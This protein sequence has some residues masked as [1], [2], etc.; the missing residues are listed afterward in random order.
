MDKNHFKKPYLIIIIFLIVIIGCYNT[1]CKKK[2][3]TVTLHPN[4]ESLSSEILLQVEKD[5]TPNFPNLI[6]DGYYFDG[7]FFED[8]K[9]FTSSMVITSKVDLYA[10]WTRI[11]YQITFDSNGGTV[12]QEKVLIPSGE[13]I[14]LPIPTKEGYIFYGWFTL[15]NN[16]YTSSTPIN[17]NV[18][19]IAKWEIP[20]YNITY[21]NAIIDTP[22]YVN[23]NE[24][25]IDF[26]N[27][28]TSFIR[29]EVTLNT[30]INYSSK[31][32]GE[33]GFFSN[34]VLINKWSWLLHYLEETNNCSDITKFFN[35]ESF[36]KDEISKLIIAFINSNINIDTYV[37]IIG[38]GTSNPLTYQKGDYYLL[39][40]PKSISKQ[41]FLGWFNDGERVDEIN[42]M[43][44]INLTLEAKWTST[45]NKI[46]F[47]L[48]GGAFG[49]D[50][51]DLY[52]DNEEVILPIPTYPGYR[53]D[54]WYS[55][56]VCYTTTKDLTGSVS[57]KAKWIEA[58][59]IVTYKNAEITSNVVYQTRSDM[60]ND[61]IND[62]MSYTHKKITINTFYSLTKEL[63]FTN[64]G[65]F[66]DKVMNNKWNWM[67][68]YLRKTALTNAR[69]EIELFLAGSK[70]NNEKYI[71]QEIQGFITETKCTAYSSIN[72]SADYTNS[73]KANGYQEDLEYFSGDNP[74]SYKYGENYKLRSPMPKEKQLFLGWSV[75]NQLVLEITSDMSCDLELV[76]IWTNKLCEINYNLNNGIFTN[77]YYDLY[78]PGNIIIDLPIPEK[79]NLVFM[80]WYENGIRRN[81]ITA[82]CISDITLDAKWGYG[83]CQVNYYNYNNQLLYTDEIEKYEL[84]I[85]RELASYNNL[86]LNWYNGRNIYDFTK[87]VESNLDLYARWGVIED[88]IDSI[89][90]SEISENL[91]MI[92]EYETPI[93]KMKIDWV[94]SNSNLVNVYN[95]K[96]NLSLAKKNVLIYG[97]FSVGGIE[98]THSFEVELKAKV[99]KSLKDIKPVFAYMANYMSYFELNDAVINTIDVI[100]YGFARVNKDFTINM[101]ELGYVN[102]VLT[103]RD[104]GIRVLLCIGAY[105]A[106]CVPFSD[107][108]ATE[109][110][111]QLLAKN[112]V[113]MVVKYGF[114]G[115]DVDW[116][117]PGYLTGRDT[118]IDK[119]NY[120]LLMAEIRRQLNEVSPDYLLTAAIPGGTDGYNRFELA[121]LN[122]IFDYIQLM[123]YDLQATERVTHHTPLLSAKEVITPYFSY[124]ISSTPYGS[125]AQS[126]D[127]F[128][129]EGVDKQKLV[130][131]IAFYGRVYHLTE[132]PQNGCVLGSTKVDTKLSN[133]MK[134][135]DI[136]N[137][138]IKNASGNADI[139]LL[140]DESAKAPYIYD[141]KNMLA[142][143]YDDPTSVA[144]KCQYVL[145]NDLGGVMFWEYSEDQTGQLLA[146]I[147]N[148]LKNK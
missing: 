75:N 109:E 90:S 146:A 143:T 33:K 37:N 129:F 40:A 141:S 13:T 3:F 106:A 103:A 5:T 41:L 105:G 35:N 147:R 138:Y 88:I 107:A 20:T 113:D 29:I 99:F 8:G 79:A 116:E 77:S 44:A 64:N 27:D 62:F 118:K 9:A 137:T 30:F 42:E 18:T 66:T 59:Y 110:G 50:Y 93:G 94:S 122:N 34:Q 114:D 32:F 54:G 76:A 131:G 38:E 48:Q 108:A 97:Y 111:R 95:G 14:E 142:I 55:N 89:F 28:F 49:D 85:N 16:E 45:Y 104:E 73:V 24:V 145:D 127:R 81:Q 4:G 92:Y 60:V 51:F 70:P 2:T 86:D 72:P 69:V 52:Y 132:P 43:M 117:Y 136:Y 123:T 7:W 135:T 26:L 10:K 102:K 130:A 98:L 128:T 1:S 12:N 25:I 61:F 139:Q 39:D 23:H 46:R 87:P 67:L 148:T 47:N 68:E 31:L 21:I 120:T 96:V 100:I 74:T 101:S 71:L 119:P 140:Y 63:V 78:L 22:K 126:V 19:L 58:S 133:Y 124:P 121:K 57:L 56:D 83:Y 6:N 53:F 17:N 134:Y 11:N 15:D 144:S 65:F 112:I 125:V 80:G 36:D 82:E 84:A 115:V 91:T